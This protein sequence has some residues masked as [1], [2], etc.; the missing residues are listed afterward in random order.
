M[1]KR[2]SSTQPKQLTVQAPNYERA[3]IGIVGI[4]PLLTHNMP[5]ETKLNIV[6]DRIDKEA[7]ATKGKKTKEAKSIDQQ[8]QEALYIVDPEAP[9]TDGRYGFPA[10]AFRL[11]CKDAAR[12]TSMKMTEAKLAFLPLVEL[13][14]IKC[15]E[16]RPRI[17]KVGGVT[18]NKPSTACVR[19]EFIDWSMDL[20]IEYDAD[21]AKLE[22]ILNLLQ[23]AGRCIGIGAWRPACGGLKG[24]FTIASE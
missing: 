7:G 16:V 4:T 21:F 23:R 18:P 12:T 19:A 2:A 17:D 10:N 3:T 20:P 14:P 6:L 13:V 15:R 11:A 5:E 8:F 22:V 1:A 9:E 24:Q